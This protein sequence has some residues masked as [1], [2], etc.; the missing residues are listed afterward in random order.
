MRY[1]KVLKRSKVMTMR[2]TV[3]ADVLEGFLLAA[4]H[5]RITMAVDPE[6][7]VPPTERRPDLVG[8]WAACM[9][10]FPEGFE[11]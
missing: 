9:C 5:A 1:S 7:D 3:R 10:Q 8:R 4:D 11:A 6:D 2:P